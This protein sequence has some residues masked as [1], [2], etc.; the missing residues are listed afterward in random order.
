MLTGQLGEQYNVSILVYAGASAVVFEPTAGDQKA[1][2][3]QALASLRAGG[4]T[5]DQA[6]IELAYTMA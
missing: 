1:K 6:G 5:N 4:S 3:K 2:L